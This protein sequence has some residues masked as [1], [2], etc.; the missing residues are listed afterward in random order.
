MK[1]FANWCAENE[2]I[3]VFE[4]GT[5]AWAEDC[6]DGARCQKQDLS[7]DYKD[8]AHKMGKVWPFKLVGKGK[9][10]KAIAPVGK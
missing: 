1:D 5:V 4:D 7:G 3:N 9:K 8:Y 10:G 6:T 2:L